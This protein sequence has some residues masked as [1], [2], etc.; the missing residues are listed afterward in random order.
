[1]SIQPWIKD[2]LTSLGFSQLTPVQ[3]STIPLLS[4]NKD[5]V[6]QA[7]TGSG[8]T[9]AFVIP[10]LE[11]ISKIYRED[12]LS[13]SHFG[14][15]VLSPTRELA[16]Q[17]AKV[18]DSILELQPENC[19][20]I[21]TQL[22]VG[23]VQSLQE[24]L[25]R[26]LTDKPQI[27]VGTP[28]RVYEFLSS[29]SVNTSSCEIL[30]L[31]EADKLLDV[32][33][34]ATTE[35]IVRFLPRQRRTGLFSATISDAGDD[36]FKTG[37]T[38]PVKITVKS[39]SLP[40]EDSSV[41]TNL[42]LF[43]MVLKPEMKLKVLL[44]LLTKYRYHKTIVYFPTC[45]GV[46][47]FYSMFENLIREIGKKEG[48]DI[49]ISLFSLHGKLEA[50]PRLR[51]LTKFA[52][53][54]TEKSVL[55][56]T[57]VAARGLDIPDVDLVIQVD[58]PTDPAM[59]L[60]RSGRTGRANKVG[61]AIAMLNE[62]REEDYVGFMAVKEVTLEQMEVPSISTD[63]SEWYDKTFRKW[64]LMDRVRYD[65]AVRSY[66]GYVRYYSKHVAS[67]IFRIRGLD[68]VSLAKMYGLTRL[69]KMPENKY[70]E[71]FPEGGFI[72]HSID[73]DRYK[74]ADK[75]K[76]A[77]RVQELRTQMRKRER[78]EKSLKKK[79]QE[80]KNSSWSD[81]TGKKETKA[82]RREKMKRRRE[83]VEAKIK[84]DGEGEAEDG[85]G[86]EDWKE[87]VL[88]SKRKKRGVIEG[89]YDL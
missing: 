56:T 78:K 89:E 41:P 7:V 71:N 74:Y 23:S 66:V 26:F 45:T 82:E 61:K 63:F 80:K 54:T 52:E 51:T 60:H 20:H 75:V 40:E 84:E 50:K 85:D 22:L 14:A 81:K 69:P 24:D 38:N 77:T 57:D 67:S 49:P 19:P 43:Y 10:V 36:I 39:S 47:Y 65:H 79:G 46:T 31:D 1:M 88:E 59:F 4:Q 87:V 34:L 29:S 68:Y 2:A 32:S 3:T 15:L 53:S 28:G 62:G 16:S 9:L 8:K 17:T 48:I 25:Q 70:V 30:I 55:F 6:V 5:V 64:Q 72:D 76:E 11:K 35:A 58:P 18:F 13:R 33:F 86:E 44:E 83:A 42:G 37:M 21:K 12:G 73:F 27:L